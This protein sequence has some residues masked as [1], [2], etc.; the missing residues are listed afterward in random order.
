MP[1]G[2]ESN[3]TG[4]GEFPSLVLGTATQYRNIFRFGTDIGEFS[5]L[6]HGSACCALGADIGEFSFLVLG[7]ACCSLAVP[8][9]LCLVW[10]LLA[11]EALFNFLQ[12]QF[13]TL[14][15]CDLKLPRESLAFGSLIH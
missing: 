8:F 14:L 10:R 3:G 13:L 5:S 15:C 1:G 9:L 2:T 7:T 6:V 4:I 12:E 11:D